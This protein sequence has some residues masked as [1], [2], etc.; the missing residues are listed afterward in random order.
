[1]KKLCL[2]SIIWLTFLS[3]FSEQTLTI[4]HT[5]DHHGRPLPFPCFKDLGGGL[6]ARK[7]LFDQI[8]KDNKNILILDAGDINDGLVESA[9]FNAEP[10]IIGYNIIGYDAMTIGNHEL[11]HSLERLNSQKKLANFPFLCANI[12]FKNHQKIGTPYLIK[13]LPNGL[14]VGI[15]GITT[16]SSQFSTSHSVS[17]Q[18]IFNDEVETA[19]KVSAQIRKQVD[20]LIGLVHLGISEDQNENYGSL[21]LAKNTNDLDLVIDGHSHTY[22]ASPIWVKQLDGDSIAVVQV[23]YWG[24]FAGEINLVYENNKTT[25]KNWTVHSINT[26]NNGKL[27]GNEIAQDPELEALLLKYKH[28]ADS[29]MNKTIITLDKD[30]DI[31]DVRKKSSEIGILISNAMVWFGKKDKVDLAFTNGGGIRNPLKKGLITKTDIFNM[32]PFENSVDI[33]ELSGKE[34]IEIINF[35]YNKKIGTGGFLQFSKEVQIDLDK[36]G[37]VVNSIKLNNKPLKPNKNYRIATNSYISDGGDGFSFFKN[38]KY[39]NHS[40]TLQRDVVELYLM[41]AYKK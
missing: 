31:A 10:D 13:T 33:I 28:K 5:N 15:I 32:L 24:A 27:L 6:P 36:S 25:L 34:L 40:Q 7:T 30:F 29:L 17:S 12:E 16:N 41:N 2:Y 21:K 20:I 9:L 4:I 39:V 19:I 37:K 11:Y 23:A 35:N 38:A 3:L 22:L 14:K 18:L 26:N 8:K 1:M